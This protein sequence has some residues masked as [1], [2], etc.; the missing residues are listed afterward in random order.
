MVFVI[1]QKMLHVAV[2]DC[3]I[4]IADQIIEDFTVDNRLKVL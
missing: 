2:F 4:A 1:S 3:R